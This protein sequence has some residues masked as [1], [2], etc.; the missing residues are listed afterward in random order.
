MTI[1]KTTKLLGEQLSLTQLQEIATIRTTDITEMIV[2]SHS[3][4]KPFLNATVRPH[5]P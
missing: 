1:S 5:K 4:V 3:S 2:H